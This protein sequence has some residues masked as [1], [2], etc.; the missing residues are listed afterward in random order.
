MQVTY[1][2]LIRLSTKYIWEGQYTVKLFNMDIYLT[3]KRKEIKVT[4]L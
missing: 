2:G 1:R 3:T 4:I